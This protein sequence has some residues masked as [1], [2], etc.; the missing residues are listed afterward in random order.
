MRLYQYTLL[1]QDGSKRKLKPCK[2][3]TLEQL[4]KILK[5]DTVTIIPAVYWKG[6]GYG[7][8]TMWGD[9]NAR[10][11]SANQQNPLFH[12]LGDGYYVVGNILMERKI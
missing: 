11:N 5:C 4:Y 10:F 8:V 9:D 12:D 7:K 2:K 6:M 3:K 1:K